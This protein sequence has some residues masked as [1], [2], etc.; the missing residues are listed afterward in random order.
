MKRE[1]RNQNNSEPKQEESK[2]EKRAE[3]DYQEP[4][5]QLAVIF[6]GVPN[7][8]NKRQEKLAHRAIMAAEPATPRYLDWSEYPIQF[9]R[10]DQWTSATNA[11][12]YPLILSKG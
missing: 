11:G 5:R 1:N 9:T 7:T 4:Q 8:R 10:E 12:C 6:S 2:E 3:G